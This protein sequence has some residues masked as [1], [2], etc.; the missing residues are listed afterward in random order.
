MICMGLSYKYM[1]LNLIKLFL[2]EVNFANN[3]YLIKTL[4]NF[5]ILSNSSCKGSQHS[6][7][8]A[9]DSLEGSTGG[10]QH[11]LDQFIKILKSF[12]TKK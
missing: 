7:L 12:F 3:P 2:D 4:S 5:K 8:K 10:L 6:I 1:K 11:I 9:K